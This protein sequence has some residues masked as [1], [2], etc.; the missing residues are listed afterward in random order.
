MM[1]IMFQP[2]EYVN[3][4]SDLYAI[5]SL[6]FTVQQGILCCVAN[7]SFGIGSDEIKLYVTGK[8]QNM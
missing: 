5:Y 7:N 8:T 4:T 2:G 6:S 1:E 3:G